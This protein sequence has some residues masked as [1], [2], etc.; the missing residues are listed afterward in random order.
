MTARWHYDNS[1]WYRLNDDL[2]DLFL[3]GGANFDVDE[4]TGESIFVLLFALCFGP[5]KAR[6]P[7]VPT[8]IDGPL[9]GGR[10]S[11]GIKRSMRPLTFV[12][13]DRIERIPSDMHMTSTTSGSAKFEPQIALRHPTSI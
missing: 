2:L 12:D 7:R 13:L 8:M 3:P 11:Q 1:P 5:Y 9:L 6:Q 10:P 4:I